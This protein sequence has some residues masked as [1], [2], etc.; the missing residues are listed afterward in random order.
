MLYDCYLTFFMVNI[1]VLM[2]VH[3]RAW[4]PE[5][6]QKSFFVEFDVDGKPNLNETFFYYELKRNF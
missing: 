6:N 4:M 3:S 2:V 1:D 5:S